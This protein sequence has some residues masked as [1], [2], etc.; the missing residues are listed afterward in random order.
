MQRQR[1][2]AFIIMLVILIMGV[3]AF[4]VSSL[5]SSAL[6]IKRDAVTADALAQAKDALIGYAVTYGD[7]HSNKAFGYLPCPDS[8]ANEGTAAGSCGSKNVSMLGRLP[9]KTLG[10]PAL[11]DGN[12]ECLW[13]A[14][15]GT[16]KNN[17]KTDLMNWD[18]NGLFQVFA[19]IGVILA[20]QT[21]DTNAVAVI[22]AP[23]VALGGQG[24]NRA[25]DG[26][27]PIC[28]GNYTASNYLDND[29]AISAN[30]AAP[31][32]VAN[33]ISQFFTSGATTNINDRVIFITKSD[34]F[35]AIKKRNDFSTFV[36][37]SLSTIATCLTAQAHPDP[38]S[39]T[40]NNPPPLF[41]TET[42]GGTLVGSLKIGRVP[43][44][45]CLASPLDN[46]QDNFLYAKCTSA[47][48]LTTVN[49]VPNCNG[50]VIF[51]GERPVSQSR[52]TNT[53]KNDWSNYLETAI[54]TTFNTGGTSFSGGTS[55]YLPASPS[56]DV[57]VCIP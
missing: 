56:T 5:N 12:G 38:V 22:F 55:S 40:F 46:W 41:T 48:C 20:G 39:M 16:Y 18:N 31:S 44:A 33:A 9:W 29:I 52:T 49:G 43:Q 3:A 19:A 23:G 47:N 28:G 8:G 32:S 26:T 57:L 6:Q 1:G 37:T 7:T 2:A 13:Y 21:P 15:S 50:V 4:L 10:L 27:A 45:L 35:S 24:Q 14:V 42:S 51:S 34:I 54:F 36:S 53:Q 25:P 30:N 11:R 17:P